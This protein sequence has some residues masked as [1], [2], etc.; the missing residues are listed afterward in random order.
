[1]LMK[2]GIFRNRKILYCS[3]T[4]TFVAHSLCARDFFCSLVVETE[5]FFYIILIIIPLCQNS[6]LII[7]TLPE[8]LCYALRINL[9]VCF[10]CGEFLKMIVRITNKI[11]LDGR[12]NV[13]L[14]LNKKMFSEG[15][16]SSF[17]LLS[18]QRKGK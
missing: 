15:F 10:N 14:T 7:V 11:Y 17:L 1:M 13:F 12:Q 6:F 9:Y 16:A 18:N 4:F 3:W 2:P 5:I 8:I